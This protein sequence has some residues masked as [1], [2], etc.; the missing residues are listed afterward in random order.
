MKMVGRLREE[1]L[2]CRQAKEARCEL[3]K[4]HLCCVSC[5]GLKVKMV[6]WDERRC[7][8]AKEA[9]CAAEWA[10]DNHP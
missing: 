1:E 5:S 2:R 4:C 6:G 9:R 10:A 7:R 8:Q 3:L